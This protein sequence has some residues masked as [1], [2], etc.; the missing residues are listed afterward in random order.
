MPWHIT[1]DHPDCSGFAVVLDSD[2]SVAG[3]HDTESDAQAQLRALY[4]TE[5]KTV[6]R[7]V[8]Y[9]KALT[10][11]TATVAGYGVIYGGADLEGESF[12]PD[13]NFMLEL[14]PTKLVLYDHSL[15]EVKHVIGK[16]SLV[17]PDEF[18]LWVEAELDRHKSYVEMVLKLVE[19]GA[20]GWSSGS[21]GHLTR[22]NGKSITQWPIV[23]LSLTPTPA[24]PRTLGVELIKSLAAV[25][26]SYQALLPETERA[27]AGRS[28]GAPVVQSEIDEEL[29]TPLV[30][31][32]SDSQAR[33]E[34]RRKEIMPEQSEAKTVMDLNPEL[35]KTITH[36][37]LEAWQALQAKEQ[38]TKAI[39]PPPLFQSPHPELSQNGAD[40]IKSRE[41]QQKRDELQAI[42]S[43]IKDA[44]PRAYLSWFHEAV[45][46]SN[47]TDMN[48]TTP[49][50]GGY[51]VP[52]GHYQRIIAK[53]DE[54]ALDTR[55]G[56]MPIPGKGT[57]VNV[58]VEAGVA[59]IFVST[60]EAAPFD[61]DAPVLGQK[62][63]T[64]VKYTKKLQLSIELIEDEDSQLMP[65][66]EDYVGRAAALT[67]NS[68]LMT[69]VL[70]GGTVVPLAGVAADEVHIPQMVYAMPDEYA[71]GAVWVM[72][73]AT[74]GGYRGLAG[75]NWQ[76]APTPPFNTSQT[77]LWGYP[78]Y[79]SQFA[80]AI[81]ASAKIMVLGNFSYVGKRQVNQITF[82]RDP[83]SSANTGQVNLFY[84]IRFVY[85]VL[86]AAPVLV[87]QLAA[88]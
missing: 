22:R 63:M 33:P 43:Y 67:Y 53:R 45:K 8:A 52:V 11:D 10:P 19:Q 23:E 38:E 87:C 81:A 58:P 73:R 7:S 12:S 46:A 78:V 6:N 26:A 75:D 37:T 16:T 51:A 60:A 65:F 14:A 50:D 56:V 41:L 83:Y 28:V 64:L 86:Q 25:D 13:T 79:H 72:R 20:L 57:T 32:K 70:A 76:F 27:H 66:L 17:E 85:E 2:N 3:C 55:V 30:L 84:Y 4:A 59:N 18:G 71:D 62:P 49:A 48:I 61:L 24:E 15:G 69:K 42:R 21:V 82:L 77:A 40:P 88:T 35:L 34:E 36:A 31:V 29:S 68:A 39:N 80:A 5:S 9:I 44:D 54:I 1:S 47:A 74:E